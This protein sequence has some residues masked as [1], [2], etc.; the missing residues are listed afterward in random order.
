MM[1]FL[2][3]AIVFQS[4]GPVGSFGASAN[5]AATNTLNIGPNGASVISKFRKLFKNDQLTMYV[6][7]V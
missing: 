2:I 1:K 7:V 3:F 4:S 5:N 6:T